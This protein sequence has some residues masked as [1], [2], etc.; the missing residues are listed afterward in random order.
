MVITPLMMP[1]WSWIT[2]ATGARQL[3]VQEALDRM[4]CLAG[5]YWSWLTPSTTVR[6]SSLAGAVMM[7]FFAPASMCAWHLGPVRKIPVDSMTTSTP[8]SAQGRP[9][10]SRSAKF[11]IFQSPT[12]MTSPS[13]EAATGSLP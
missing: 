1:N 6:S 10:G 12:T 9:W 3:V 13:T 8:Y 2:L 7:T 4:W 5:S 11:L